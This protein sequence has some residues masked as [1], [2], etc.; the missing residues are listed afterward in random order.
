MKKTVIML[1]MIGVGL[2]SCDF[3]D[4]QPSNARTTK[5]LESVKQVLGSWQNVFKNYPG[6]TPAEYIGIP[7]P[8]VTNY[9]S[10]TY[11]Q[12]VNNWTFNAYN[13]SSTDLAYS[14]I[15]VL[16]WTVINTSDWAKYYE[17]VGFMNLILADALQAEGDDEAMRDYIRGEALIQRAYYLFKLLQLY[18]DYH[19]DKLGIPVYLE[20]YDSY[21]DADL[22]RKSH[23]QVYKQILDDLEKVETLLSRTE[24]RSSYNTMYDR[25]VLYRLIAQ[26]Y[27]FK[28]GSPAG[29][30]ADWTKAV[31]YADLAIAGKEPQT[32]DQVTTALQG[33]AMASLTTT[34][35]EILLSFNEDARMAMFGLFPY[36]R[37][38]SWNFSL[39][40]WNALYENNDRRKKEWFLASNKWS[41]PIVDIVASDLNAVATCKFKVGASYQ[42]I[43]ALFR[44]SEQFLIKAE[45]L[46]RS[47]NMPEAITVLDRWKA[48]RYS[49][50]NYTIPTDAAAYIQEVW[51]ERQREFV[52]ES[53][54]NW[55]DMKRFNATESRTV[56]GVTYNLGGADAWKYN[57][58]IPDS[59][60][61]NNKQLQQNPGWENVNAM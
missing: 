30:P 60:L 40:K 24:P 21:L 32:I 46:A 5:D 44:L 53:D 49:D 22:G 56:K 8:W 42:N 45:A 10:T 11:I 37:V 51:K 34:K 17:L 14:E 33:Q 4:V 25:E 59:E 2:S 7:K 36:P 16:D 48:S 61:L 13:S 26:V 29:E 23:T 28:G 18:G 27:L 47:G 20:I 12:Y 31:K 9:R 1:L 6:S 3:L 41:T 35:P 15:R 52:L 43:V 57:F 50:A 58:R 54:I 39:D 55:L 38:A 19:D